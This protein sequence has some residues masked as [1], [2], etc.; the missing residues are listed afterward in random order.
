[1]PAVE[2]DPLQVAVAFCVY[3]TDP[4]S[5]SELFGF[6]GRSGSAQSEDPQHASY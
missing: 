6:E 4:A 2:V 5:P 3:R 1:M